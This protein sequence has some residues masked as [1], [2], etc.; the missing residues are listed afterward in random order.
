MLMVRWRRTLSFRKAF[1]A[2]E[3]HLDASYRRNR[4]SEP[5]ATVDASGGHRLAP[6]A[7]DLCTCVGSVSDKRDSPVFMLV[8]CMFSMHL[9]GILRP[10]IAHRPPISIRLMWKRWRRWPFDIGLR[11]PPRETS[12]LPRMR[13]S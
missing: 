13:R 11:S 5:R 3:V 4:L 6:P 1:G 2:R 7:E 12:S 10:W 8:L 9:H